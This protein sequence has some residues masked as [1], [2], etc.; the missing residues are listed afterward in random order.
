MASFQEINNL[1]DWMEFLKQ[2]AKQ[3][4]VIFK[5]STTCPISARAWQEVQ[6]FIKDDSQEDV[7]VAMVKVIE[8]R[9]I[10]QQ[11]AG[12]LGV[13]HQSPQAIVLSEKKVLWHA[14]HGAIT[15]DHIKDAL[16]TGK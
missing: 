16:T 2:S 9:T 5:H 6:D 10:S 12:D 3:K 15:K 14:S 7:V 1:Q 11:I 4:I 13:Q 8:A